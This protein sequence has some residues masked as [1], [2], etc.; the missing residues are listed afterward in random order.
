MTVRLLLDEHYSDEIAAALRE[1]G[2]DVIAVALD[3]ELP[4]STDMEVFRDAAAHGRRIVTENIK[5][6]RPLLLQAVAASGPTASLLLV[7][8]RRFPRGRGNRTAVIVT[9]LHVWLDRPDAQ[10]RPLEDWLT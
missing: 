10:Q 6:F 4:G 8:P 5:D 9:A 7:P 2:H 1:L 3:P